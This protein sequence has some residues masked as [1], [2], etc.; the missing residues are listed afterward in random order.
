MTK[1]EFL[2]HF[3]TACEPGKAA[4][5]G[6]EY[7]I[8]DYFL[9]HER[10]AN[11]ISWC[12]AEGLIEKLPTFMDADLWAVLLSKDGFAIKYLAQDERTPELIKIAVS[13]DGFAIQ[14]LTQE[15]RT[16]EL[17]KFV[18]NKNKLVW[19]LLTAEEKI[20]VKLIAK[21]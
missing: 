7:S 16:P 2:T 8:K 19:Y 4:F 17:V 6:S 11:A 1:Q 3:P 20:M 12:F 21:Q 14:Y 18:Y 10:G 13:N 5:L 15:E 9:K